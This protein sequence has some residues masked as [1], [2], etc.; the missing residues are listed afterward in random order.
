MAWVAAAGGSG[1]RDAIR[2]ALRLLPG[3]SVLRRPWWRRRGRPCLDSGAPTR[4]WWFGDVW[5]AVLQ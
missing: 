5:L 1:G 4:G 2:G 3:A